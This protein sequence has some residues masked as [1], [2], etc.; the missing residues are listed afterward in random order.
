MKLLFSTS[1]LLLMGLVSG[2]QAAV[3]SIEKAT[4]I[5]PNAPGFTLR[6]RPASEPN[7]WSDL[8]A[9]VKTPTK[10]FKFS[11]TSSNGYS[12]NYMVPSWKDAPEDAEFHLFLYGKDF[13]TL[14]LP[15]KGGL[16]PEAILTPDIGPMVYYIEPEKVQEYLPPE[17]WRLGKCE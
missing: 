15:S 1:A 16:A 9:T 10:E 17:M 13:A 11:M 3:C 12:L 8:E 6:F 5:Q 2:G 14:E 7:S 4:Y